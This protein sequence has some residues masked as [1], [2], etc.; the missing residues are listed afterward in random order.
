MIAA[1]ELRIGNYFHP[2]DTRGGVTIPNTTIIWKVGSID[3]F[4]KVAV[5]EPSNENNIYLTIYE[6]SPI[7]LTPE[8]LEKCGFEKSKKQED[9]FCLFMNQFTFIDL[10]NDGE[11]YHVFLRQFDSSDKSINDCVLIDSTLF[12]LHQLQNL[13]YALTGEE[14]NYIP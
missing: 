9:G 7:P 4:G 12:H 2:C 14:L 6:C 3:K 10:D 11:G 5:I 1:N 8:I 13:Y